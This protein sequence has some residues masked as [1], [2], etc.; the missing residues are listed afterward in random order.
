[1][2]NTIAP[3]DPEF[4]VEWLPDE[5]VLEGSPSRGF[6]TVEVVGYKLSLAER[7]AIDWRKRRQGENGTRKIGQVPEGVGGEVPRR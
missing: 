6:R 3:H 5:G 1:M 4:E 7:F 2:D